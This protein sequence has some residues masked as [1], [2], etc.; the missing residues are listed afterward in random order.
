MWGTALTGGGAQWVVLV[1]V[2][3]W[4]LRLCSVIIISVQSE[5]P[6]PQWRVFRLVLICLNLIQRYNLKRLIHRSV[7]RL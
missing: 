7:A 5:A 1:V 2:V 3:K 4:L 6:S